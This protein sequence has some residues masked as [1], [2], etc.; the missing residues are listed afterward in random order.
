MLSPPLAFPTV[1]GIFLMCKTPVFF[2]MHTI[3]IIHLCPQCA[4]EEFITFLQHDLNIAAALKAFRGYICL[5]YVYQRN[6][7]LFK[8]IDS[9]QTDKGS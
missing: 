2:P 8:L 4:Q 1:P 9:A 7:V 6:S 3:S 5:R